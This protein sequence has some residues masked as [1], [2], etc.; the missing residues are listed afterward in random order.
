M[1]LKPR[2]AIDMDEVIADAQSALVS[3]LGTTYGYA[4]REEQFEGVRLSALIRPEH[5]QAMEQMLH[6]GRI[7]RD[8]AVMPGSQIAVRRLMER[9]DVFITTA[10]MEYPGSCDAKFAWLSEHFPFISPLNIVFC[11]DKSILA[12]DYLLDDTERHF[13]RFGGTGVLFS[14]PHNRRASWRTVVR[15]WDEAV[16]Y[17]E[18]QNPRH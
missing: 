14:A 16:E 10:A 1:S 8:Y 13:A 5:A 15:G 7:F 3:W 18:S 12:T 4:F 9:F 17:L 11:G 2:L 6:E